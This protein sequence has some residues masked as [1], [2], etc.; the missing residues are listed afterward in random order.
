MINILNITD[1]KFELN[2]QTVPNKLSSIG[3]AMRSILMYRDA[4]EAVGLQLSV[5]FENNETNESILKYGLLV[6]FGI[7]KSE[8]FAKGESRAGVITSP[9]TLRM[10]DLTAGALRGT[11]ALKTKESKLK[12][13]ILPDIKIED[14]AQTLLIEKVESKQ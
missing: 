1:A 13:A 12:N 5:E 7:N 9:L 3:V 10:L 4:S 2:E 14:L 8:L 6:T 11:L